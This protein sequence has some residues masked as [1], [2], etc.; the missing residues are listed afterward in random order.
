MR[1]EK[2]ADPGIG[3]TR[4]A[5]VGPQISIWNAVCCLM[6][7]SSESSLSVM[8]ALHKGSKNAPR[9]P[10][11]ANDQREE[12]LGSGVEGREPRGELS[13]STPTGSSPR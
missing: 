3:A 12:E 11:P 5:R 7:A 6:N 4:L 1:L 13:S 10:L 2:N 8:R 9:Y